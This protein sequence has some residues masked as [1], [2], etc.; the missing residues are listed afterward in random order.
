VVDRRLVSRVLLGLAFLIAFT[1]GLLGLFESARSQARLRKRVTGG[2]ELAAAADAKHL[3]AV[4]GPGTAQAWLAACQH[5]VQS[6]LAEEAEVFDLTGRR[7]AAYPGPAPVS[8]WLSPAALYGVRTGVPATVGPLGGPSVRVFHYARATSGGQE[9]VVRLAA[10][11]ADLVEDLRDH[12]RLFWVQGVALVVL[13][14][15]SLLAMRTGGGRGEAPPAP[16][17]KAYE[18]A[19]EQLRHQGE[20]RFRTHGNAVKRLE[21]QLQD[22]EAMA[23]AGELTA[24]MVHEVR[25]GLGT[26]L[27]YAALLPSAASEQVGP[28]AASIADEC[29]ALEGVVRRFMDFVRP[30]NLRVAPF[31]LPRMLQ[32]VVARECRTP[33]AEVAVSARPGAPFEGDEELLEHAFDNLVRNAREA[34]GPGGHVGVEVAD[35]GRAVTVQVRDDG[36]GLPEAGALVRPF[37]STKPGGL[38]LGL[39]LAVKLVRLHRGEVAFEPNAPRGLVVMVRL[40]RG[41]DAPGVTVGNGPDAPRV[42]EAGPAS[43]ATH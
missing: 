8:H 25:N 15:A 36:P 24:G 6:G 37:A 38:G 18:Q 23:R 33:G 1:V 42:E 10:P 32:R 7:L 13:V 16:A 26:I 34:A 17:L 29:R 40:P 9:V 27:G 4:L 2:L 28:L 35:D 3:A 43:V 5:A 19:V 41:S 21:E 12:R 22:Q 11:A 31:D 14:G 20:E 30:E 39:P